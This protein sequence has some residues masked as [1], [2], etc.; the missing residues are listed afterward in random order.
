MGILISFDISSDF[1]FFKKPDIN[2]VG[3]SY[4]IPPKPA[5]LGILG[6]I[7]G[8]GGLGKQYEET[9]QLEKLSEILSVKDQNKRKQLIEKV[10]FDTVKTMIRNSKFEKRD[11]LIELLNIL[12]DK[13]GNFD[14]LKETLADMKS[15]LKYPEFYRQLEHLKIG[16]MPPKTNFPFHKIM[17]KYN[18]RNSYYLTDDNDGTANISEQLLI[19]PEYRI[20]VYDENDAILKELIRRIQDNNPIFMPY[21]GKNEFII[22]LNNLEIIYNCTPTE[23]AP[24]QIHSIFI[25]KDDIE[26]KHSLNLAKTKPVEMSDSVMVSGLPLGFKFIEQYPVSYSEEMHY[27]LRMAKYTSRSDEISTVDLKNG[28]ITK[29]NDQVIYLF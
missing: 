13:N 6:S 11:R 16:I 26:Q 12:V 1:G 14:E 5:I 25:T 27:V 8:M 28:I 19:R 7:L 3:L 21:L 23:N 15:N 2:E 17:N 10:D 9:N 22:S 29:I 24:E 20:Y 4:N 18:S